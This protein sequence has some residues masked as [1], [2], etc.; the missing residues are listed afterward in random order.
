MKSVL[1]KFGWSS[2]EQKAWSIY[3]SLLFLMASVGGVILARGEKAAGVLAGV[4]VV[5]AFCCPAALDQLRC[6]RFWILVS[7][8]PLIGWLFLGEERDLFPGGLAFSSQGLLLGLQMAM[9][10]ATIL[11][12]M[13]AFTKS[14]SISELAALLSQW[15]MGEMGFVL[16]LAVNLLPAVRRTSANTLAAMRLRGGFRRRPWR[17]LRLMLITILANALRYGDEVV[18]A[19]EARAFDGLV[20]GRHPPTMVASDALVVGFLL[21]TISLALI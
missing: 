16:G 4:V 17:A 5:V 14:A 11:I 1:G 18:C 6:R 9:R 8:F 12:A 7:S 20:R 2:E 13:S 15:G 10:A 3:G 21:I 19:A